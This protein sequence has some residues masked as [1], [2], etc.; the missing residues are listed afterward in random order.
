MTTIGEKCTEED[1]ELFYEECLEDVAESMEITDFSKMEEGNRDLQDEGQQGQASH[2]SECTGGCC[3]YCRNCACYPKG[4]YCFEKCSNRRRLTIADEETN[5]ASFLVATG[6]IQ[7]KVIQCLKR[8]A[9]EGY[10]CI[11]DP[12]DIK[13]KL[14]IFE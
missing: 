12:G 11:G 9:E 1:Q 14:F 3:Q 10:T 8:K 5:T 7:R 13:L 2:S 6:Q 4:H